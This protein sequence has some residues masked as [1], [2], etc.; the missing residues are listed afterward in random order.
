MILGFAEVMVSI[1]ND[2]EKL[3]PEEK[4]IRIGNYKLAG[5]GYMKLVIIYLVLLL[6]INL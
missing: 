5:M 3:M 4:K 6:K 1:D 2:L